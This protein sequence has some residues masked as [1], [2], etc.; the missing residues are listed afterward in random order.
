MEEISV[1]IREP[2]GLE[3]KVVVSLS[4]A[5]EQVNA[6]RSKV[7]SEASCKRD[8]VRLVYR[9]LPMMDFRK[10]SA[11]RMEESP[12]LPVYAILSPEPKPIDKP[13]LPNFLAEDN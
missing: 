7:A 10:L 3:R 1:V 11:Y 12:G 8:S 9:G 4:S 13:K 5:E 6:L 2:S